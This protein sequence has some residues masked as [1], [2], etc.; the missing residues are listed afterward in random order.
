M[1]PIQRI[2]QINEQ[3]AFKAAEDAKHYEVVDSNHQ[4]QEVI[5]K[6]FSSLIDYLD[7]KVTKT[8]VINQL[9]T[10][11]TPDVAYVVSAL[12]GMHETL[13]A[14]E[15]TDLSEITA[16]MR[17]VLAEAKAIP[18]EKVDITIPEQ[19]FVDYS[20]RFTSL[21]SA[22]NAITE[23]VKDI[24]TTVEAPVVNVPETKVN[25]DAPDLK[26]L[27]KGLDAVEKAVKSLVFP[28]YKTDN[29][30]VEKLLQKTNKTLAEI[31]DKP[32]GGS[33]GGGGRTTP[34]ATADGNAA[35]VTLSSQGAIPTSAE[36]LATK[37]TVS[38]S[39]T[40]VGEALPG[41]AYS[42]ATWRV[43]KIDASGNITWLDGNANFDNTATD[44][45]TGSYL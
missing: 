41:T 12:N 14:H 33:S 25:V 9:E 29:A 39:N 16:V 38:G 11:S 42:A 15:N 6:S 8:E 26:P 23:A 40:Y 44:L 22:I 27:S 24:E 43:Q 4:T 21:E 1:D 28:E 32:T 5:L 19:E 17:E 18:K 2:T 10:I 20:D 45:T 7:N 13:Q 37:I 34:Y 31:L 30:E 3:N 36:T 35:F